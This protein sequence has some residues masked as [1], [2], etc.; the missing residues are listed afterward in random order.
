MPDKISAAPP[1]P[2]RGKWLPLTI[3]IVLLIALFLRLGTWQLNRRAERLAANAEIIA[4]TE[5]PPLTV[6]GELLDPEEANLRR[7][8][9]RGVFDYSQELVLRNR[10]WNDYPGV[11]VL[12]PLKIDGSDTAILVDRG[13][14]P[15]ESAAPEGRAEFQNAQ[16]EV[17][18]YG[19]LRQS[20]ERRGSFSPQDPAPSPENRSDAWHR[21]DLPKI[22]QQ[23]P[24]SLQTVYLEE[25][26]QPGETP[27]LFPKPQ[28]DISLDEGSHLLYAIQWFAFAMIAAVGYVALYRQRTQ[29]ARRTSAEQTT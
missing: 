27:R 5:L 8:T 3:V 10:T 14:I 6:T 20:Q 12:T 16:G 23:L 29:D 28:P 17:E 24:Y 1:S 13:W 19:I 9:V 26:T 15:Y 4:R 22:R 18:V 21:V 7:A 25:D 2:F 11:H